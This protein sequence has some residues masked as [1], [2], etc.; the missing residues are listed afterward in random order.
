MCLCPADSCRQWPL[1]RR[2]AA[3][4][5][6]ADEALGSGPWRCGSMP[7]LDCFTIGNTQPYATSSPSSFELVSPLQLKLHE[8]S[9]FVMLHY[10]RHLAE[11]ACLHAYPGKPN[12]HPAVTVQVFGE[13]LWQ[14]SLRP[15]LSAVDRNQELFS[16]CQAGPANQTVMRSLTKGRASLTGN[17]RRWHGSCFNHT[18]C[19]DSSPGHCLFVLSLTTV[20][21]AGSTLLAYY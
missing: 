18:L 9:R 12:T 13:H 1:S 11:F 20:L 8:C 7:G 14:R 6:Q 4:L 21:T 5:R 16:V 2:V 15:P 3:V 10:D 19:P 17:R